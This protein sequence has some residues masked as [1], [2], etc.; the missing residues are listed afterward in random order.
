MSAAGNES[1]EYVVEY[2]DG[3]L[4]DRTDRRLLVRGAYDERLGAI[5]AVDGLESTFWYTA[6]EKREIQ[7]L[8]HVKYHFDAPDSDPIEVD[9]SQDL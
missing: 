4:A 3:P 9:R 6:G 5:E 8:L 7:G 2:V 1:H